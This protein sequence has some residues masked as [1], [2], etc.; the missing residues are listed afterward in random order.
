MNL[1]IGDSAVLSGRFEDNFVK[2]EANNAYPMYRHQ[3]KS[4]GNNYELIK[5]GSIGIKP[6]SNAQKCVDS[7]IFGC[8]R[9][10][11]LE[12]SGHIVACF[13]DAKVLV[14][15]YL[16]I[17]NDIDDETCKEEI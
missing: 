17:E 16:E 9:I 4:I 8:G 3:Q 2:P 6:G 14:S 7:L 10:D 13:R 11:F 12:K 1:R 5:T 15:A